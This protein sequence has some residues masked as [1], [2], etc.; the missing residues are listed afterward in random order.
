MVELLEMQICKSPLENFH[1]VS[2]LNDSII[3]EIYVKDVSPN[4]FFEHVTPQP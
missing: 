1:M 4:E 2:T 3:I